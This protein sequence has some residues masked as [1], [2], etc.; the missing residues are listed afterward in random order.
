M[1][2]TPTKPVCCL[3]ADDPIHVTHQHEPGPDCRCGWS[4]DVVV[5]GVARAGRDV[6]VAWRDPAHPEVTG[7]TVYPCDAELPILDVAA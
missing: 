5:E 4:L 2:A 3:R 7:V 6:A 1:T